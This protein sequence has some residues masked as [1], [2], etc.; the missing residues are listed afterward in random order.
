MTERPVWEME[1]EDPPY[2][3]L[4]SERFDPRQARDKDGKWT[5]GSGALLL[6]IRELARAEGVEAEL[7]AEWELSLPGLLERSQ[8]AERSAETKGWRWVGEME[9]IAATFAG[10]DLPAGFHEAAG[11]VFRR[12]PG[13]GGASDDSDVTTPSRPS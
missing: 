7:F 13:L 12:S 9:E 6:A 1:L 4:E 11:E 8:R 3:M 2:W 5:K 10:V